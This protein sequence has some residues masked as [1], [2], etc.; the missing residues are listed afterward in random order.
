NMMQSTPGSYLA[1]DGVVG[2]QTWSA[3]LIP[4]KLGDESLAVQAVNDYFDIGST[5]HFTEVTKEHVLKFQRA[6][7]S[8]GLEVSGE[9]DRLTW[10]ALISGIENSSDARNVMVS[11]AKRWYDLNIAYNQQ[12]WFEGWRTDCSGLVSMAWNLRDAKGNKISAVTWTLDNYST[13]IHP[14]DLKPGDAVNAAAGHVVLFEKWIDKSQWKFQS[15]E[16]ANPTADMEHRIYSLFQRND[17]TWG[18]KYAN[19]TVDTH[20]R[21]WVALRPNSLK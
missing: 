2:P 21:N 10:K 8:V 13:P 20:Y 12:G 18:R 5:Q 3:L 1:A 9:V 4:V 17:G 7:K 16:Q 6:N 14:R 15:Y 11:R 19:G